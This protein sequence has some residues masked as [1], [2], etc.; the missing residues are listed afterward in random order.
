LRSSIVFFL[1]FL[2]LLPFFHISFINAIYKAFLTQSV[3]H[4]VRLPSFRKPTVDEIACHILNHTYLSFLSSYFSISILYIS[5]FCYER[6]QPTLVFLF[7]KKVNFFQP[8]PWRH[9][10]TAI[11]VLK[12]LKFSNS[13]DKWSDLS[14]IECPLT[15]VD[16]SDNK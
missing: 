2:S 6:Y 11:A 5:L 8:T 9:I 3:T 13:C 14:P 7:Y 15:D 1:V 10:I 16:I 4:L 12:I